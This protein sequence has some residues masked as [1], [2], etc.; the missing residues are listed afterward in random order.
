MS[1]KRLS[2]LLNK[3]YKSNPTAVLFKSVEGM[4]I[5]SSNNLTVIG[6]ANEV[7]N[8]DSTLSDDE[9]ITSLLKK[10]CF[11]EK[12]INCRKVNKKSSKLKRMV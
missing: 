3:L 2:T 4:S 5:P 9:K 8:S 11:S 1:G 10:L 7:N 6:I 12:E